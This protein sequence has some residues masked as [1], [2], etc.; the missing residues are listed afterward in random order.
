MYDLKTKSHIIKN[1]RALEAHTNF[2]QGYSDAE[3]NSMSDD[4]LTSY[5]VKLMKRVKL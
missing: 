5:H 3:L 2:G 4:Q 1:M